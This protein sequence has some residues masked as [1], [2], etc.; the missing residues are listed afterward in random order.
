MTEIG[1]KRTKLIDSAT[2][3]LIASLGQLA[4]SLAL[5]LTGWFSTKLL[6]GDDGNIQDIPENYNAI[7]NLNEAQASFLAAELIPWIA[8]I[9]LVLW[10]LKTLNEEYF[11]ELE[12]NG[13]GQQVTDDIA[14]ALGAAFGFT[15]TDNDIE[16][17][18]NGWLRN[19]GEMTDVYARIRE[20]AT[21][22]VSARMPMVDFLKLLRVEIE[23]DETITGLIRA[24]FRTIV[25]DVYAEYDRQVGYKYAI[26]LGYRAAIYEGGL[27]DHSRPFCIVRNGQVFT[28]EEIQKFGTPLDKY[29]G[30]KDKSTGYFEG[31]PKIGYDPFFE[32]GGYNCRHAYSYIPDRLAIHLR[33]ELQEVF[34]RLNI[35]ARAR[36]N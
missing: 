5:F 22:A 24:H 13:V 1:K 3:K 4:T 15:V 36:A 31:K 17:L 33:P 19:L 20:A 6:V 2:D 12:P 27:I 25:H 29:E 32:Q 26:A 21:R 35:A 30:Y 11:G 10:N 8:G 9:G 14:D 16:I 7:N 18:P 23:G 28:F 34:T